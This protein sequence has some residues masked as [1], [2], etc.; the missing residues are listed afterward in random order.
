MAVFLDFVKAFDSLGRNV[1]FAKLEYYG[2]KGLALNWFKNYLS[3]RKQCVKYRG[4]ESELLTTRYGTAQ[5]S[6]LGPLLYLIFVNDIVHCSSILKFT[7][8]ADDTC[9]Y[10]SDRNAVTRVG[11]NPGFLQKKTTH[12]G[13][14]EK[15]MGFLE[16]YGFNGFL[17]FKWV[18]KRNV[19]KSKFT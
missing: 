5:G 12:P 3:D 19:T 4:V 17:K 14:L 7:M 16:K 10:F 11:K 8:Y 1:L 6:V 2:I 9:V 18:F 13:F 15:P